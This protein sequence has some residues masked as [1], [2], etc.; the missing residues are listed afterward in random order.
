MKTIKM[1]CLIKHNWS[2]WLEIAYTQGFKFRH[3]FLCKKIQSKG[4]IKSNTL[5]FN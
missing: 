2:N 1:K 3:C 5:R 4:N